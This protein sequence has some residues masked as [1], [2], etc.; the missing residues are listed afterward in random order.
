MTPIEMMEF[1][2]EKIAS[3]KSNKDFL[4]AMKS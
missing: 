2:N 3:T 1:L 4:G